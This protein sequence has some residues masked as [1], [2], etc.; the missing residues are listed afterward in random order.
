MLIAGGSAN[1]CG[2]V[3]MAAWVVWCGAEQGMPGGVRVDCRLGTLADVL[4]P[5]W[6]GPG[7]FVGPWLVW[8]THAGVPQAGVPQAGVVVPCLCDTGWCF[9][10]LRPLWREHITHCVLGPAYGLA[11]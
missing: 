5:G 10:P 11:Q 3:S 1:V 2:V 9:G 4:D 7:W 8:W 6:C